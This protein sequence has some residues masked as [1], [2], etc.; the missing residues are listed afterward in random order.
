MIVTPCFI[1]GLSFPSNCA[2]ASI[3]KAVVAIVSMVKAL[4]LLIIHIVM[5]HGSWVILHQ[6]VI[7]MVLSYTHSLI[8]TASPLDVSRIS[9]I[10]STYWRMAGISCRR[11]DGISHYSNWLVHSAI[12]LYLHILL[13]GEAR[14]EERPDMSPVLALLTDQ[15]KVFCTS[16]Y[17]RLPVH[18]LVS[19]LCHGFVEPFSIKYQQVWNWS[20]V[21]PVWY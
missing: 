12:L 1:N 14:R 20:I 2:S 16:Q 9:T 21:R 13:A 7:I 6:Q 18:Q 19:V 15:A 17:Q 11:P 8:S 4:H 5:G 3:P 10:L